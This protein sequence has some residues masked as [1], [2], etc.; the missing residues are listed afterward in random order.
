MES[1]FYTYIDALYMKIRSLLYSLFNSLSSDDQL[2]LQSVLNKINATNDPFL[3][4]LANN[5]LRLV[6]DIFNAYMKENNLSTD[7]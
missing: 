1:I 5:H 6:E 4:T 7:I 2:H 3:I